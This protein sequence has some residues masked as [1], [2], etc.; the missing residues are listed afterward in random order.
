VGSDGPGLWDRIGQAAYLES[1]SPYE[2]PFT[3]RQFTNDE[4]YQSGR[5]QHELERGTARIEG[6]LNYVRMRY[7]SALEQ[8]ANL[9]RGH[10]AGTSGATFSGVMESLPARA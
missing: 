2:P 6:V 4:V 7:D 1:H 10:P 8:L 9:R 5:L 3:G